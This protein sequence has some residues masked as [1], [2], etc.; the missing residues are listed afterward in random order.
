MGGLGNKD[1]ARYRKTRTP[2]GK[3]A[4]IKA[5]CS[6]CMANYADGRVDCTIPECPLYPFMPYTAENMAKRGISP[7]EM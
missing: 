7:R 2:L 6:D 1:L 4:A 5:K 3:T